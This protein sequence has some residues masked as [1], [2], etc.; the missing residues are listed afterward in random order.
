VDPFDPVPPLTPVTHDTP[1]SE[2]PWP[3]PPLW[4]DRR[5]A[6]LALAA[7]RADLGPPALLL[8]LP[9][10]GVPVA[11][12]MAEQLRLPLATWSVR[13][14]SDPRAPEVAIGAVAP[15]GLCVWRNGGAALEREAR[16]R[17]Q[18]WLA[19]EVEELERRRQLFA[20][21]SPDQLQG[22]S[23][24][25]VDDGIATGMTVE[26][27]L[28]SLRLL[29]PATLELAVP[30]A[31]REVLASLAP[32]ADRITVLAAV[33]WLEAVGLWYRH[34]DQLSDRAVQALLAQQG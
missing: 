15:G 29:A 4:H 13:K 30:V 32:L 18:G 6:G 8:A 21:P 23:L 20:D 28:R 27:A 5:E 9:R 25:L 14:V 10:G 11:A 19:R 7:V 31:D 22:R 24:V 26:A 2:S 17:Q 12:A 1:V 16:A 34:F 33:P 3:R